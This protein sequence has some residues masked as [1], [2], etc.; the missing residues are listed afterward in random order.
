[1][2][3]KRKG[4]YVKSVP[5]GKRTSQRGSRGS[6][7]FE[8][9]WCIFASSTSHFL[10]TGMN[11][12]IWNDQPNTGNFIKLLLRMY[13]MYPRESFRNARSH[14][15][16]QSTSVLWLQISKTRSLAGTSSPEKMTLV[17]FIFSNRKGHNANQ[18]LKKKA[19][20]FRL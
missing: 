5:S 12:K 11:S 8:S 10:S 2:T 17:L 16:I 20:T 1:M 3:A 4:T 19:V 7:N 6:L 18:E 15:Y 14:R 9:I 13:F